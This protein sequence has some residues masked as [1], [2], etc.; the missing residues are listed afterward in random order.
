M[1]FKGFH[2]KILKHLSRDKSSLS[3]Y[4]IIRTMVIFVMIRAAF[5]QEFESVFVCLLSLILLM[6]PAIIERTLKI[7]LPTTLEIII[8]V[9]IFAAEILGEIGEYYVKFPYWDTMLHTTN[10][11][12]C[13]AIGFSMVDILNRSE[14]TSLKLSPIYMSVAA[15]CFSMT[16]GVLWEF[17]EFAADM[18]VHTDMQKD[19]VIDAIYSVALNPT[20]ANKPIGISGITSVAVNGTELGLGGYLDIG[21][22]DTMQDLFV[23]FIGAVVFSTIGFFYVKNR[24]KGRF[25]RRFI[26]VVVEEAAEDGSAD[27]AGSDGKD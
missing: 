5:R 6:M 22:I 15:F 1:K 10:G 16:V 12:L 25:A 13:A 26:P 9:F 7:D 2:Q 27:D 24:G 20:G 14:R 18:L 17:F 19:T 11:F 8:M 21:L 4:I 23:N 3:V